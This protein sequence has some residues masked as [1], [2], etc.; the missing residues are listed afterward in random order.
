MSHQQDVRQVGDMCCVAAIVLS[1]AR[2]SHML[3]CSTAV[4]ASPS[5][6]E[7]TKG[8]QAS[9]VSVVMV[10]IINRHH[11]FHRFISRPFAPAPLK[12]FEATSL[13]STRC[14]HQP[15]LSQTTV[16]ESS[17]VNFG[18]SCVELFRTLISRNNVPSPPWTSRIT[19]YVITT[20]TRVSTISTSIIPEANNS[21]R[22]REELQQTEDGEKTEG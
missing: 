5:S 13:V 19:Q 8:L 10:I 2:V 16:Q 11:V 1:V 14:R 15:A 3:R 17:V 9:F 4:R 21:Q 18:S 20:I 6:I 12:R 7:Y 22:V